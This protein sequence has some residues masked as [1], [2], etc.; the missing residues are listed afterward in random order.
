MMLQIISSHL[1]HVQSLWDWPIYNDD[2]VPQALRRTWDFFP[3]LPD[4]IQSFFFFCYFL[5]VHLFQYFLSQ[6]FHLF[7][8]YVNL[9]ITLQDLAGDKEVTLTLLRF[10]M[11]YCNSV[12]TELNFEVKNQFS[13]SPLFFLCMYV[14]I[15]PL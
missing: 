11:S 7:S 2:D 13:A 6:A 15:L 12:I 5:K 9:Y 4:S 14:S 1:V 10:L 3:Q 8:F